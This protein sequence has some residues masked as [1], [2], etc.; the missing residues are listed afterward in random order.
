M[1]LYSLPGVDDAKEMSIR[2]WSGKQAAADSQGLLSWL[3]QDVASWTQIGIAGL[4]SVMLYSLLGLKGD[5]DAFLLQE[6]LSG[7]A[8]CCLS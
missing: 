5:V 4:Q 7:T 8:F 1:V 6:T 2:R 3:M